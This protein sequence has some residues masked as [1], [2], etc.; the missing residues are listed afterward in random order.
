LQK[1]WWD[2]LS[3]AERVLHA[4]YEQNA[5]L[6]LRDVAR[7]E[8]IQPELEKLLQRMQKVDSQAT[9]GAQKLAQSL[10]A[11]MSLSGLLKAL[12]KE[13]AKQLEAI[14]NRVKAV[15]QNVK[16]QLTKNRALI[17]NELNYV[18]GTLSM[19]AKL[20]SENKGPYKQSNSGATLLDQVT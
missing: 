19:I 17:Q 13:E 2:W 9:E 20:G 3:T 16:T 10:N 12:E 14:S 15:A 18:S 11:E 6:V 8:K 1:L 5:A 7:I 4:L